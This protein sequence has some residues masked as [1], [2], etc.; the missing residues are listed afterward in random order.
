MTRLWL[1]SLVASAIITCSAMSCAHAGDMSGTIDD[2]AGLFVDGQTF[3]FTL[4]KARED[5]G[6]QGMQNFDQALLNLYKAGTITLEEAMSHADSRSNLEAKIN[7][8][9]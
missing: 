2:K 4:G 7:F 3:R 9:G 6:E 8:G 1:N 5:S